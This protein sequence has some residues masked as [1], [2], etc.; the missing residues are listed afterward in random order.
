MEISTPEKPELLSAKE[1]FRNL[2]NDIRDG[3]VIPFLGAGVSIHASSPQHG[4]IPMTSTL[5]WD[6]C[7]DMLHWVGG[8][9]P[10]EEGLH[11]NAS[12]RL[13]EFFTERKLLS[14]R[15]CLQ[16]DN[17]SP[18][19]WYREEKNKEKAKRLNCHASRCGLTYAAETYLSLW[20]C[21]KRAR[22]NLFRENGP[23]PLDFFAALE[24]NPCH[25]Y[26]AYLAREGFLDEVITTNYDCCLERA[27]DESFGQKYVQGKGPTKAITSLAGYRTEAWRWFEGQREKRRLVLKV[28]KING[29]ADSSSKP[30]DA[31]TSY[32]SILITDRDLQSLEHRK[33]ARDFIADRIRGC[34]LFF[35]GFGSDE[36]Q[37]RFM[38]LEILRELQVSK[39]DQSESAPTATN[40]NTPRNTQL[41][42]H[43]YDAV[44]T[45]NQNQILKANSDFLNHD[46]ALSVCLSGHDRAFFSQEP[47]GSPVLEADLLWQRIFEQL[48]LERLAREVQ[49][50]E[51]SYFLSF[52]GISY[53]TD[54][55]DW[56]RK[57]I[58][59]Y[60][61]PC[62]LLVTEQE[63]KKSMLLFKLVHAFLKEG[64]IG[65]VCPPGWYAAL[66]DH[67]LTIPLLIWF[68][69]FLQ[70]NSD[71]P[72]REIDLTVA[73]AFSGLGVI[74]E[75]RPPCPAGAEANWAQLAPT[76]LLLTNKADHISDEDIPERFREQP[77]Y[78][79]IFT[80]RLHPSRGLKSRCIR[81]TKRL[82]EC[83]LKGT[84]TEFIKNLPTPLEQELEAA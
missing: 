41:Y 62:Q 12:A 49:I 54:F 32:D 22:K 40:R 75:Y 44:P 18:E 57:K 30:S 33:W 27:Y 52:L 2:L 70:K 34:R 48:F 25:Q 76:L 10:K 14:L 43:A 69:H 82:S 36:P 3:A 64:E 11:P 77:L 23:F 20:K 78:R 73:H 68:F 47:N 51:A 17:F 31:D 16:Q 5:V 38:A 58:E 46:S 84:T 72:D 19:E 50:G 26:I 67:P 55:M 45:W 53:A 63:D 60:G 7:L 59:N 56:L 83:H 13:D 24:P 4:K 61:S 65:G 80:T 6:I 79:I 66:E 81:V 8:H 21:Q 1:R 9:N 37:I 71:H 15:R 42:L 35:S 28:Y 74:Y 39:P 29:C